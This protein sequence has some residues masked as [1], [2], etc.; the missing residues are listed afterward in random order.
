MKNNGISNYFDL[1]LEDIDVRQFTLSLMSK[2]YK[3]NIFTMREIESIQSQ[4]LTLLGAYILKYT[5]HDSCSVK[6][7]RAQ[8]IFQS[9][10]YCIDLYLMS[11]Q[12]IEDSINLLKN[13]NIT[14]LHTKG[15]NLAKSY[16][17]EA[18]II[19]QEIK[20]SK[21]NV[22][23]AAYDITIDEG[24]DNFF[25]NYDVTFDAHNTVASID[26][27]L[28]YDDMS[29]TG[30]LYMINY[31][32][33]LQMENE[34][35]RYF[36]PDDMEQLLKNYG[37]QY[38]FD[39]K[40][41]LINISELVLKNALFSVLLGKSATVLTI[42]LNECN[43]LY[44]I[45]RDLTKQQCWGKIQNA[46]DEIINELD[47][48]NLLLKEYLYQ[49]LYAFFPA[50]FN[51]IQKNT[52]SSLMVISQIGDPQPVLL[53]EAGE[54]LSDEKLRATIDELLQCRDGSAKVSLIMSEIH[55]LDDL[56]E[57][58]GADCIFDREYDFIF[59]IL[60]DYEMAM[61]AV[62]FLDYIPCAS[63]PSMVVDDWHRPVN[64]T[65]WLEQYVNYLQKLDTGKREKIID[66]AKNFKDN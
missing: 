19:D 56:I 61:L 35:C 10:F 12:N 3:A 2:G 41:M 37:K 40:E 16:V 45:L 44:E 8:S 17:H 4:V 43:F 55:N 22:S 13:T 29:L 1:K 49:F 11:F 60:N 38:G 54:K 6:E 51:A 42:S 27:P 34:F 23:L 57:I 64:E 53:Y 36:S 48:T 50:L 59:E 26:Y 31:L 28:L 15:L 65:R 58:L 14:E 18:E 39:F 46:L 66:L 9:I 30:I 47:M 32:K 20:S 21:L 5:H 62:R 24:I 52:L 63:N 25:K 33:K 7:E